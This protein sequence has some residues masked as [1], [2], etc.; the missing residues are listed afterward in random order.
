[1][2]EHCELEKQKQNSSLYIAVKVSKDLQVSVLNEVKA[3]AIQTRKE[4][5]LNQSMNIKYQ[6]E[7]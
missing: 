3:N 4:Q 7:T 1:M 6:K 2:I 5:T